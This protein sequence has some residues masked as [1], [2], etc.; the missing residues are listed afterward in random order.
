MIELNYERN[1]TISSEN[2]LMVTIQADS[3][4]LYLNRKFIMPSM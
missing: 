3:Y 4:F 1:L 2:Q